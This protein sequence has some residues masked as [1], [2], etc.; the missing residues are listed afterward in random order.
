MNNNNLNN[1]NITTTPPSTTSSNP[2][3]TLDTTKNNVSKPKLREKLTLLALDRKLPLLKLLLLL[4]LAL[5]REG[6]VV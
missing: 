3:L 4:P 5:S 2:T 6:L 1:S